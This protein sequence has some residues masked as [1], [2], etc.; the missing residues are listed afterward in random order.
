M[1]YLNDG[2]QQT[3]EKF[4]FSFK[5]QFCLH[6]VNVNV[7]S[8]MSESSRTISDDPDQ[9]NQTL[10]HVNPLIISLNNTSPTLKYKPSNAAGK[11]RR[12]TQEAFLHL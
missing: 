2:S 11:N 7:E 6:G 1:C 5:S 10:Q 4:L 9:T 12:I 3:F 8:F